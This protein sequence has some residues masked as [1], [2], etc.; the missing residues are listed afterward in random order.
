MK[1]REL[2][3][4]AIYRHFKNKNYATMGISLP[5]SFEDI[6][7]YC[8]EHNTR[9]TK[10]LD[11]NAI[12]TEKKDVI[13][14]IFKIEGGWYH[15]E[16][17]CQDKLVL[18]KSLYDNKGCYAR[19]YDIFLSKVDKKK[20]P[21]VAQE[22]RFEC[23]SKSSK[24]K[25]SIRKNTQSEI[26]LY[27]RKV[28]CLTNNK[29][30]KNIEEASNYI[31]ESPDLLKRKCRGYSMNNYCGFDKEIGQ[32]LF[33]MYYDK[34]LDYIC[35]NGSV[36]TPIFN[37]TYQRKVI[38]LNTGRIYFS[39]VSASRQFNID[40]NELK[41]A[42]KKNNFRT[43]AGYKKTEDGILECFEWMY[44]DDYLNLCKDNIFDIS[45]T[46]VICLNTN[47]IYDS[48]KEASIQLNIPQRE[49]LNCCCT[50]KSSNRF[51]CKEDNEFYKWRLY[52]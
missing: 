49:I 25:E 35:E 19:P 6:D 14:D 51:K 37:K 47:V 24:P 11:F 20:Y 41:E 3:Y 15:L 45:N 38:C 16:D 22:F 12:F 2:K 33:W 5:L 34:Y 30:F 4:P 39:I 44:H 43:W 42:C 31:G 46:K 48:I 36:P 50:K 26:N 13:I 21:N 8:I 40:L 1:K 52:N 29:V 18:Y 9:P 23:I 10:L 7:D 28:I 32:P 27:D 17:D